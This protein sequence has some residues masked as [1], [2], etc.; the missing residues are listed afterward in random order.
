MSARVTFE[1]LTSDAACCFWAQ[2]QMP[3][4]VLGLGRWA[5]EVECRTTD[6]LAQARESARALGGTAKSARLAWDGGWAV[7]RPEA[8]EALVKMGGRS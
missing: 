1:F 7:V 5:V 6:E 8:A 2:L 3:A 4:F